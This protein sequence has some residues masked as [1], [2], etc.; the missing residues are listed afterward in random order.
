MFKIFFSGR[1]CKSLLGFTLFFMVFWS[2]TE[3][4]PNKHD[5][6]VL[7]NSLSLELIAQE[8]D[9]MTPIGM[10]IDANDAIYILE[11]HTH[12]VKEGYSGPK[13]DR[14]KKSIDKNKDGIPEEWIVYADS[15]EDGMNLA[16]GNQK[17]LFLSTKN[18][19]LK[20]LDSNADGVY[21]TKETVLEM[22]KPDDVYDHAG[23]LGV[24][25]G[26]EDWIYVSRG[27]TGGAYWQV[28]GTDGSS[29]EGYGDGG[30][31][32]RCKVDGSQL[33]QIA[34]GFWN[35]F[36]L[37]FNNEGRLFV[38]DNDP[39]SRGPNRLIE[40]VPG[41]DYGYKSLY[42]GSGIHPY[43][44]W[45]GELPGTLS[46]AAPLGEAPC[47]LIDAT[48]TNFGNDY[49]SQVLVNVWEEN[50]IVRIPLHSDV[51]TV[52]GEPEILVQ[53]D[54]LFHPVALAAN[55]NGD[56]YITDWVMR[57]YPNHGKGKIWRIKSNANTLESS[58]SKISGNRFV[59]DERKPDEL[60]S[61]LADDDTFE[62][63]IARH[64]L[65]QRA[66]ASE[67]MPLLKNKDP[68]LR[69][70][71][72]LT[73]FNRQEV[74]SLDDLE[75]LLLDEDDEVRKTALIYVG[76]KGVKEIRSKL[77][78]MLK[79]NNI[80]SGLFETFLATIRHL[81]PEFIEGLH[82][83]SGKSANV[84]RELPSGFIRNILENPNINETVKATALPYLS[85]FES[86]SELIIELLENAKEEALQVALLMAIRET[87]DSDLSKALKEVCLNTVNSDKVRSMALLALSYY[88]KEYLNEVLS[89]LKSENEVLRYAAIKYLCLLP[90]EEPIRAQAKKWIESHSDELSDSS[91]SLWDSCEGKKAETSLDKERYE[92]V[93]NSGNPEIGQ[94]VY[95][96]PA[97]LCTT[98]HKVNDWGGAFGPELSKIASSKSQQQL[99]DAILKPSLDISPEWQGWYLVDKDGVRHTGR[100]IDIHEDYA[101]LMN[102]NG[103]YDNF[104][105]PK[106]YGTMES[107]LM[108]EG[109]HNSMTVLEFNDL[110]SYLMTLK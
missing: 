93:N 80:E 108:P 41:G 53:G 72:L 104:T 25:L 33:E 78:T 22:V 59:K 20:Y 21:D 97:S 75:L 86:N 5:I 44:S 101:E 23:I 9:I 13:Y 58:P 42:G 48:Y 61:A 45:N 11:S 103:D 7:D 30:N 63:A 6:K 73:F 91:L 102:V 39:D 106:S 34:T 15:I 40:I 87:E 67:L 38:T 66:T 29:I 57:Q 89:F 60:L 77:L 2:C 31:V 105:Y 79:E 36:D 82:T 94:L 65:V 71:I 12:S 26:P 3:E 85:D 10:A 8:P 109:L 110:I 83:K 51:S 35:P 81:Q 47:A 43:Q 32:M 62:Q 14:I 1:Y 50:T 92:T 70:Q 19:I 54:S 17:G 76:R 84:K 99:I 88:P 64:Y 16:H 24:T 98:C 56:L 74:L 90:H 49:D 68:E 4:K 28:K 18:S 27:N 100:Q 107:S 37:K 55:S 95:Q 52:R 69:L 96:N 46:Y